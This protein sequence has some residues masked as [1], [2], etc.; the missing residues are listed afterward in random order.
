MTSNF[1]SLALLVQYAWLQVAAGHDVSFK[2]GGPSANVTRMLDKM[3]AMNWRHVLLND[4]TDFQKTGKRNCALRRRS[5]VQNTINH[6]RAAIQD[7]SVKFPDYL[8]Y[9]VAELLYNA[10]EHGKKLANINGNRVIIP[11]VFSYGYYPLLNRL[12]FLFSDL[13]IGIK[14]HLESYYPPFAHHAEAILY[15]LTPQVSGTFGTNNGPYAAQDNAGLG[16]T[17]SSLMLKRLN[18]DMYIVSQDGLVHV[19]PEDVTS[20]QMSSRWPGTFVLVNINMKSPIDV[21]LAELMQDID[22]KAFSEVKASNESV[23]ELAKN[24]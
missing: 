24:I 11:S 10:T 21:T 1:Q 14:A 4:G 18:A 23:Q 20:R 3:G 19:S 6:A 16:L 22:R 7:T 9:I 13:G 12:S 2:Y 8:S 17:Y 15:A 5:D